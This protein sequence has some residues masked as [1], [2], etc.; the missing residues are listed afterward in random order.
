MSTPPIDISRDH[1]GKTMG[2]TY[3]VKVAQ[4]PE[5]GD[6]Q[7]VTDEIQARLDALDRMMSTYK[8]DSEVCRFNDFSSTED[9]FSVSK[10][11]AQV[12]HAAL[13]I[14]RLSEG[15]FDLTVAPLVRHWGFG[16]GAS[17]RLAQSFE[18]LQSSSAP[19]KERTGYEKLS[20]RLDPPALKKAIP[21][22][23]IDLSAIAKGFA[24]D[25]VAEVLE[26]HKIA[27]YLIEVGGEVRAKGRNVYRDRDWFVEVEKPTERYSGRQQAFPL[28]DQSL[29]T[30]GS[31]LQYREIGGQR[32]SHLIDPR[33]GSPAQIGDGA[34][35][36]VTVAVLAPNCMQADAWATAMFVLGEHKGLELANKHK[37]AVLFLLRTGDEIRE[38]SSEAWK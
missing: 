37:L 16:A 29:A 25:C 26:A 28:K 19:I 5:N 10:E 30:S 18:E 14:S 31:Y 1:I 23:T 9:W 32:V 11:T 27:D 3:A 21:E 20:V 4:F 35:K 24:V 8:P 36:L 13:E 33:S 6:W 22:L 15:A 12:V 34:E 17:S 7:K 2:T 38:V